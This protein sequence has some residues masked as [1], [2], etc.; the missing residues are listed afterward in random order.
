MLSHGE[1]PKLQGGRLDF[2][3]EACRSLARVGLHALGQISTLKIRHWFTTERCAAMRVKEEVNWIMMIFANVSLL[4]Y[5][6]HSLD[7]Q[8]G[9]G[10]GRH[11]SFLTAETRSCYSKAG[12]AGWDICVSNRGVWTVLE[13]QSFYVEHAFRWSFRTDGS[14]VQILSHRMLAPVII[15]GKKN[16]KK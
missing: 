11:L 14:Q 16:T 12:A 4:G 10:R 6:T 5:M 7:F 9:E 8:P 13:I 3:S 1:A 2:V 15:A